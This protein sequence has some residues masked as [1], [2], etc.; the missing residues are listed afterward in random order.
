M[1]V[2]ASVLAMLRDYFLSNVD[3]DGSG[4]LSKQELFEHIKELLEKCTAAPLGQDDLELLHEVEHCRY[5]EMDL[6]LG[7]SKQGGLGVDEWIHFMLLRASSPSH[8]ASKH[9]NR[10]LRNALTEDA[11]LLHRL[12]LAF[13]AADVE[14]DGLLRQEVWST[15]FQAVGMSHPPEEVGFDR[16]E[17]GSP[18]ALSYYEFVGHALGMTAS[19]IEI[20]LYDLSQGVAKWVP[21]TLLGGHKFEGVWHSGVRAFG[22]EFWFGGIIIESNFQDVPFGA[23][24]KILRLGTTL[25][26][27]EELLDFLKEDVYVDYNPRSYDV[28]RRNCNHFSN[29]LIQFLFH[30]KQLPEEILLQPEWVQDAALVSVLQPMLNR[31]LG[32]FGDEQS[33]HGDE[34]SMPQSVSRVDDMTE[35]WRKRLQAGDLVM[36][37]TRFIDRPRPA[38]LISVAHQEGQGGTA[39]IRFLRPLAVEK[40]DDVTSE[41]PWS[42][43]VVSQLGVP[44]RQFYPLL[45]EVDGSAHILKASSVQRDARVRV[46]L[47]RSRIMQPTCRKGHR[48]CLDSCNWWSARWLAT[49]AV[50]GTSKEGFRQGC[51]RCKFAI[52]D[53]CVQKGCALPGG[54]AFADMLS[55]DL[56]KS[57]LKDKGWLKYKAGCY[58]YKADH[59]GAGTIDKHKARRVGARLAAE[60]GVKQLGDSELMKEMRRDLPEGSISPELEENAFQEFFARALSRALALLKSGKGYRSKTCSISC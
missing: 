14:G 19:V 37:R 57:L 17:D 35:E 39:E 2:S 44:L 4:H 47:S 3:A 18:W 31:W 32:G 23:P 49:C 53:D 7:T 22:K 42:W 52:C 25:R 20:A 43:E 21:S 34:P 11:Q 5:A 60:L 1:D 58:F 41:S 48:L 15:A 38:R 45:D 55:Q 33:A 8:I 16:E 54:G 30:G 9:L 12:H 28:L 29:E 40:W 10:R 51:T 50:C 36:H 59:N 56:A 13:E 46:V 27:Y 24:T 6:G 26:T